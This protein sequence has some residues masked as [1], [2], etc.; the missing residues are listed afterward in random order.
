MTSIQ[1]SQEAG[2]EV[3]YSCLVKNLPQFVVIHTVKGFSLVNEADVDI[4]WNSLAFFYD[5]LDIGNLAHNFLEL[6]SI[7]V[8]FD[9]KLSTLGIYPQKFIEWCKIYIQWSPII[10]GGCIPGLPVDA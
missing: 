8:V 3:W 1:V 4:F 6:E 2:K 7:L 5:P 10:Y 9:L